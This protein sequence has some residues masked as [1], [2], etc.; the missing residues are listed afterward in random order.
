MTNVWWVNQKEKIGNKV[1]HSV[2]W[3][4]GDTPHA[5]QPW[6]WKTMWDV[7]EGDIIVHYSSKDQE[8][9]A[10]SKA[11]SKAHPAKNPF[12]NSNSGGYIPRGKQIGVDLKHLNEPIAK[13][14]IPLNVRQ[15]ASGTYEPFESN[16]EDIKQGYFFPVP[17]D[18]W[19]AIQKLLDDTGQALP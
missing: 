3:S 4:P 6:H 5:S 7:E 1:D 8:I 15:A 10:I 19:Q 14:N 18:L 11:N 17:E 9:V 13:A 16:G 12:S 2:I